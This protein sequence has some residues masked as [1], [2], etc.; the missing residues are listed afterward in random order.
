MPSP[1]DPERPEPGAE[2]A[3]PSTAERL[4]RARAAP[5]PTSPNVDPGTL[6]RELP[7]FLTGQLDVVPDTGPDQDVDP[8]VLAT[9]VDLG[10]AEDEARDAIAT[11]RVALVLSRQ[12]LDDKPSMTIDDLERESGVSA[13]DLHLVRSAMGLPIEERYS[14][15]DLEWANQIGEMLEVFDIDTVVRSARARGNAI[16]SMVMSDLSTVRDG[17]ILPLRRAGADDVTIGI[18]LAEATKALDPTSRA[19][20]LTTYGMQLRHLL[21]TELAAN[22]ARGTTSQLRLAVGFADIVGFTR[23]SA[24]IDPTGL[25]SL[26]DTFESRVVEV[27]SNRPDIGVVKYLGDAVMLVGP[28][29]PTLAEALLELV[30]E[31]DALADAPVRAGLATGEVLARDGDYFGPA[32]NL[33]A[34]LTDVSRPWRV[35]VAEE[36]IDEVRRRYKVVRIRP[37]RL[38]GVGTTRP[39]SIQREL[40]H[41]ELSDAEVARAYEASIDEGA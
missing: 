11:D 31:V 40:T 16:T 6:P 26:I 27:T 1:D 37:M 12:L 30:E 10:I 7:E 19:L 4:R 29:A 38:R 3:P 32:V 25:D 34:R 24:R 14:Q 15:L 9:L 17:L 5:R 21:G 41:E 39:G 23:L 35:L 8:D 36:D 20:I 22:A 13:G 33:A 18:A 28:N 2:D